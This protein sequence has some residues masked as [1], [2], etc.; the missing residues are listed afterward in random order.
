MNGMRIKGAIPALFEVINLS[1][2]KGDGGMADE[3]MGRDHKRPRER[4][5]GIETFVWRMRLR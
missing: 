3:R 1:C 5:A 2:G 4:S